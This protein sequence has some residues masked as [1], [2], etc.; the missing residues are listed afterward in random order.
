MA[1]ITTASLDLFRALATDAGNWSG[2]PLFDGDKRERGN[3][4]D[5]KKR[6][7]LVTYTDEGC[8]FVTFTPKG[9]EFAHTNLGVAIDHCDN[10]A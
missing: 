8:T 6:G 10:L 7:L 5:L 1:T 2:T 9:V 3:L 4:T